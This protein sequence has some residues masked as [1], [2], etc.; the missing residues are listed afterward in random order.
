MIARK[1]GH[2]RVSDDAGS[3]F[4]AAELIPGSFSVTGEIDQVH[5]EGFA[6]WAREGNEAELQRLLEMS[7]LSGMEIVYDMAI[8]GDAWS[9][10]Y[11]HPS[12]E[13]IAWV[14]A[15]GERRAVRP[16]DDDTE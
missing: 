15:S 10:V 4:E 14:N 5:A 2:L 9:P 12:R 8:F 7:R 1:L 16:D 13:P 3:S 6:A 11:L